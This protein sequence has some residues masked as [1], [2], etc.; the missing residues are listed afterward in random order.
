M[1]E[2]FVGISGSSLDS[3]YVAKYI[4]LEGNEEEKAQ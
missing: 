4:S 1:P 3:V 2:M